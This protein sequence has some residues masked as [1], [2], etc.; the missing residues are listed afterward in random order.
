MG[1]NI[2]SLKI[3]DITV[4]N[5]VNN[6]NESIEYNNLKIDSKGLIVNGE[7]DADT[8]QAGTYQEERSLSLDELEDILN[9]P[10]K[11]DTDNLYGTEIDQKLFAKGV[12]SVSELCGKFSALVSVGFSH[13]DAASLLISRETAQHNIDI[14]KIQDTQTKVN[15]EI[16]SI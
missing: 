9:A 3:T 12:K 4:E 2:E 8:I 1:K 16:N 15:N 13:E 7:I 5:Q 10:F 6:S 11:L 14:A